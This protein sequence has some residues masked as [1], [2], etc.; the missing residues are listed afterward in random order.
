VDLGIA[1]RCALVVGAGGGLGGA[2]ARALGAERARVAVA[3]LDLDAAT[4]TAR[5]IADAGGEAIALKLDLRDPEHFPDALSEIRDRYGDIDILVNNTG[6]PPPSS[7]AGLAPSV[8]L[9]H[10]ESMVLSVIRLTDLVLPAMRQGG[11]GRVITS[12][13]SG[14]VAPI[15]NLAVSNALR[16]SLL[17]W[18]KTLAAEVGRDGIT[19]N[20]I[21]PGRIATQRIR[22]LDEARAGREGKTVEEV[23][24]ESTGAIPLGRYGAP[25]EYGAAATFLASAVGSYIT[26]SVVRVDGG[27]IPSI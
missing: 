1:D 16:L 9:G 15:P 27:L 6:G 8:W 20:V 24:R 7:A 21:L 23:A 22:Q 13:S 10:F 11:W 2:I 3:D 18:S 5:D 19:V 26:G 4:T 17:G 12:A 14:V 25:A